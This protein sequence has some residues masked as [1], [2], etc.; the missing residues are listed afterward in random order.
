MKRLT[1]IKAIRAN[2]LNCSGKA[3]EVRNCLQSD[4]PLFVYRFGTNPNRKGIGG[5]RKIE[6]LDMA[7]LVTQIA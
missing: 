7:T 1:P 2:C 5:Q 4:C 6:N 3:R